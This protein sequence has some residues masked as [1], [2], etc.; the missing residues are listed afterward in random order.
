MQGSD[1]HGPAGAILGKALAMQTLKILEAL[2]D[3][4]AAALPLVLTALVTG[5]TLLAVG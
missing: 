2:A 4:L 5:A 3:R 1:G